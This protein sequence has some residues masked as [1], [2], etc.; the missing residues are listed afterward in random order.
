MGND[1]PDGEFIV[2]SFVQNYD[3]TRII[4]NNDEHIV[5]LFFDGIPVLLRSAIE[6]I[7]MRTWG[8]VQSKYNDRYIFRKSFFFEVRNSE[9]VKWCVEEG[10]GFYE[11]HQLKHYCIVTSEEMIDIVSTFE[12]EIKVSFVSD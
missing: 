11:E 7:R 1:I 5:D 6:E 4:L 10:C 3:G 12:P 2:T 9:L 8:S